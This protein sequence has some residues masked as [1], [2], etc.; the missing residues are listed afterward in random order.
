MRDFLTSISSMIIIQ[1]S[2]MHD[3]NPEKRCFHCIIQK[4]PKVSIGEIYSVSQKFLME[5]L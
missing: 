4:E 1:F 2:L 5:M 3:K